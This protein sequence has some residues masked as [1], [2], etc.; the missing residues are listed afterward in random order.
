LDRTEIKTEMERLYNARNQLVEDG[1]YQKADD[2]AR[3]LFAEKNQL[4]ITGFER[5]L[6]TLA[7]DILFATKELR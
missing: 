5:M 6:K 2:I 7:N 1:I 4:D 3:L